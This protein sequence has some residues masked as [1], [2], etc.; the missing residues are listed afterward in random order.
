[1]GETGQ[2]KCWWGRKGLKIEEQDGSGDD[3]GKPRQDPKTGSPQTGEKARG[4]G[5]KAGAK[6]WMRKMQDMGWEGAKTRLGWA[7]GTGADPT[8]D[9]GSIKAMVTAY[10]DEGGKMREEYR[11]GHGGGQEGP[12]PTTAGT[13]GSFE[14]LQTG[15]LGTRVGAWLLLKPTLSDQLCAEQE[16]TGLLVTVLRTLWPGSRQEGHSG[17]QVSTGEGWAAR[18]CPIFQL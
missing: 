1:M 5:S 8:S 12:L 13:G 6:A 16:D 15:E 2:F 4:R 17:E 7:I 9:V 10:G 18:S 14:R 11:A 3:A